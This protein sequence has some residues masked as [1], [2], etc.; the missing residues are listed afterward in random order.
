ME[1]S[2]TFFTKAE[3]NIILLLDKKADEGN[4]GNF[5][6]RKAGDLV[7]IRNQDADEADQVNK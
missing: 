5:D 4:S 3:L 7:W 1:S 2:D 6:V